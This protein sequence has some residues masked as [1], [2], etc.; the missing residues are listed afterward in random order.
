M[1]FGWEITPFHGAFVFDGSWWWF[2]VCNSTKQWC[3]F[4]I[5]VK[6]KKHQKKRKI[7]EELLGRTRG[8]KLRRQVKARYECAR[9][10]QPTSKSHFLAFRKKNAVSSWTSWKGVFWPNIK[11]NCREGRPRYT[12]L[13]IFLAFQEINEAAESNYFCKVIFGIWSYKYTAS[14]PARI[15]WTK[16]QDVLKTSGSSHV[17][18][19]VGGIAKG[20]G[21]TIE[22]ML[23]LNN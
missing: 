15:L 23:R 7:L 17:Y 10:L 4:H 16:L 6:H 14:T 22:T 20:Q 19:Q 21:L 1:P 9:W 8:K 12:V 2:S 18:R 11:K 13:Y 5:R 3:W